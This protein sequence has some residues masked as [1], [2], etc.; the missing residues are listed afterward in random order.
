MMTELA[1]NLSLDHYYDRVQNCPRFLSKNHNK[2]MIQITLP[3]III[4]LQEKNCEPGVNQHPGH[5]RHAQ[6][7]RLSKSDLLELHCSSCMEPTTLV[8]LLGYR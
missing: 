6:A 3:V 7:N 4:S 5:N 8:K 2:V 1:Y